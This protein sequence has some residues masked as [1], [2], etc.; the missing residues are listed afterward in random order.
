MTVP[1]RYILAAI[2]FGIAA[3]GLFLLPTDAAMTMDGDVGQGVR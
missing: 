3:L 1:T 2:A